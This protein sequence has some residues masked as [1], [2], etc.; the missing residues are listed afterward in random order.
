MNG[1]VIFDARSGTSVFSMVLRPGLGLAA[2]SAALDDSSA[3]AT[4]AAMS[5]GVL[6]NAAAIGQGGGS[7]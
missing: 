3:A 6:L 2:V 4:V 5:F 7:C 1:F